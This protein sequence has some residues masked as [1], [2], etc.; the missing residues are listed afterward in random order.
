MRY[1]EFIKTGIQTLNRNYQLLVIQMGA[2]VLAFILFIIIVG[3]PLII[4][5]S[6]IGLELPEKG[7]TELFEILINNFSLYKTFA[8]SIAISLFSYLLISLFLFVYII[9]GTCGVLMDSL[10]GGETFSWRH[11][12]HQ[13]KELFGSFLSLSIVGILL[14]LLI[15]FFAGLIGGITKVLSPGQGDFLENFYTNLLNLISILFTLSIIILFMATLTYGAGIMSIERQGALKS[16]KSSVIFIFKNPDALLFFVIL[17]LT[18]IILTIT[19]GLVS[20]LF[21]GFSFVVYQLIL[22]LVQIYVNLAIISSSFAYLTK[23]Q[24]LMSEI[25]GQSS[26]VRV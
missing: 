25:R 1:L 19:T 3:I 20:L 2:L 18:A 9:A 6:K 13:G 15:S 8:L 7:L 23:E 24:K 17:S 14:F 10:K 21:K 5:F 12:T 4:A 11:F 16:L 26:E 22:S